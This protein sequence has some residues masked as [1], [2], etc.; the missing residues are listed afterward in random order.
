M[1]ITNHEI[2][3]KEHKELEEKIARMEVKYKF[4]KDQVQ[5]ELAENEDVSLS[6][7]SKR[8]T[9]LAEGYATNE[10][11]ALINKMIDK[12]KQL[13]MVMADEITGSYYDSDG[14]DAVMNPK[15]FDQVIN[16]FKEMLE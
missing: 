4:I 7:I 11:N 16:Q 6:T 15:Y 9:E 1:G 10:K 13:K 8:I 2:I 12:L 5:R 14:D 3:A